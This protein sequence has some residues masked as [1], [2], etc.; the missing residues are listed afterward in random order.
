MTGTDP[1]RPNKIVGPAI[2]FLAAAVAMGPLWWRGAACGS[3]MVFHF[4]SW[5]DAEHSMSLG[6][7]YPHWANSANNYAGEPRFIFYPPLSW[8]AGA[9]MGA[10]LPWNLVPLVFSFLLLAGTGLAVRGL[11]QEAM[12]EGPATLAGCAA[13]FL[14]FALFTVYKR[15]DFAEMMGG[16]W[17]PLL[18]LFALRRKNPSGRFW[19]RVFDGST[20]PLALVM[21]GIWLSNGPVGI[22]A[23]YLLA[24]VALISALLEK[25]WAPLA[26]AAVA[27]GAGMGMTSFY[28]LPA[29]WE[30]KWASIQ[31]AVTAKQY[32]FENGWLFGRHAD[33]SLASHDALLQRVSL[34][35]VEMLAVTLLG[36]LVAWARGTLPGERRWWLPL[37]LIPVA[38]LFLLLPISQPVWNFAPAFRYLQFPWRWLLVLE[39]PMAISFASAVWFSR[40][41]LR[42]VA[43]VLCT[44]LF[45]GVSVMES[46]LWF[47]DC[48]HDETALQQRIQEGLG[49]PGKPEY[50]PPGIQ[51]AVV[52]RVLHGACLLD[53]PP[54]A[55]GQGEA[56]STPAWD[57]KA[58]SCK[59]NFQAAMYLPENKW[60]TGMA[61]HA[62][63]L[64]LRL[65]Y[66]PAWR[67]A[68][69]GSPVTAVA[70]SE[71]GLMAVPVPQGNLRVT[72]DWSTTADVIAGRWLS[73]VSPIL[74][75]ALGWW[76]R[77]RLRLPVSR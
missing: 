62:G 3:D 11:A 55:P 41:L 2:I 12:A 49:A 64:I 33:P 69:N 28:L 36:G 23:S 66:Y 1:Q 59:G 60:V 10:V 7:P 40:G 74:L 9:A 19:E 76:E 56:G 4:V 22:M 61:D 42:I 67:V 37:A 46:R 54:A 14:G 20:T 68:V 75:L 77:K 52:D 47:V 5:I 26:R 29:V 71:C 24:A 73:S 58:G 31:F 72:V 43:L 51:N 15:C 21:A 32:L 63:Y 70:E 65:R 13:I 45:L 44:V 18:L 8:M 50:A 39:A 27:T 25:S 16:F 48:N 35:A 34:V 57:G 53:N 30:R 6:V 17:I 38:V